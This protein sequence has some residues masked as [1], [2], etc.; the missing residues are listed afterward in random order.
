MKNSFI[1]KYKEKKSNISEEIIFF[2]S[3]ESTLGLT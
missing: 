2:I 1:N 3:L